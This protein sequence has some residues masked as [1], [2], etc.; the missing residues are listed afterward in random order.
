[1]LQTTRPRLA[2]D[3]GYPHKRAESVQ[4]TRYR[5]TLFHRTCRQPIKNIRILATML[6]FERIGRLQS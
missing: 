5:S 2:L 4:N 3:G 6:S 1:M